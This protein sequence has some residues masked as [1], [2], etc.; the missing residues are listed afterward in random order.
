MLLHAFEVLEYCIN[1]SCCFPGCSRSVRRGMMVHPLLHAAPRVLPA[2]QPPG[3]VDVVLPQPRNATSLLRSLV[4]SGVGVR[5]SKVA[6]LATAVANSSHASAIADCEYANLRSIAHELITAQHTCEKAR[7]DT[8]SRDEIFDELQRNFTAAKQ[9]SQPAVATLARTVR[10]VAR[11]IET[12]RQVDANVDN[13]V[14]TAFELLKAAEARRAQEE[15]QARETL[16][17]ARAEAARDR[18]ALRRE[19]QDECAA[20]RLERLKAALRLVSNWR[21]AVTTGKLEYD[22]LGRLIRSELEA[23]DAARLA[24]SQ[25]AAIER[26]SLADALETSELETQEVLR[27]KQDVLDQMARERSEAESAMDRMSSD[28]ANAMDEARLEI[29]NI[30]LGKRAL[31]AKLNTTTAEAHRR[32]NELMHEVASWKHYGANTDAHLVQTTSTLLAQKAEVQKVRAIRMAHPRPS[33]PIHRVHSCSS[34][35]SKRVALVFT[36]RV[37]PLVV[38]RGTGGRVRSTDADD[39]GARGRAKAP[40]H[41][42]GECGR[43]SARRPGTDAALLRERQACQQKAEWGQCSSSSCGA[44][45]R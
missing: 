18:E 4:P 11:M 13:F 17:A 28:H 5:L 29:R 36:L 22:A 33:T 32:E 16:R 43:C 12:S 27:E 30:R 38:G 6:A 44:C 42:R 41:S 20:E 1:T 8:P 39:Q 45:P 26:Q 34:I 2:S 14:K 35:D 10:A 15:L 3:P 37:N 21:S 25:R 24:D 23:M 7:K 9:D 19:L 40:S 31:E